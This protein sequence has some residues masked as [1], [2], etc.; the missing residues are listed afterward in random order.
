MATP[1]YN[2]KR[3]LWIIQAQKNG[4]KKVFYSSKKGQKG[5]REVLQKYDDWLEGGDSG[6]ITVSKCVELY[7]EDIEARLGRRDTYRATELYTRLYVLP[8]LGKCKMNNLSLRDWQSILNN[9]KRVKEDKPLSYKTLTHIRGIITGLHKF[10]YNN[11]YC[12]A[13]RGS[14]YIPQGHKKGERQI[15]QPQDI[16]RLFEPSDLWYINAFRVMLLC[17]LRPGECLGLQENDIGDGVLEIKRSINDDGDI[18]EGKNKNAR[19]VVPLPPL[20]ESLLRE[21]IDRNHKARFKTAWIFPNG[22]GGQ[23][24]QDCV[25]K[26]WNKLKDER[27]L[28]GT[29]YSLR[30]TFVSIVS[31]QTHLAEG[32]IKE[33]VGH[34]KSMDTF[35]TYKHTL[36][37]ELEGAAEI[38]NL[39]FERLK[40]E[41]E[42]V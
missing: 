8:A 41:G 30:H 3:E 19:R 28:P 14:L 4:I 11:Y 6:S 37:G 20:A 29:P 31:S 25:R 18:T 40:A 38:I 9:A 42:N 23:S 39:T 17:G 1:I 12:E 21:T 10:A 36:K 26:Q 24:N 32:T 5:F 7:L 35:G 2:K 27:G 33:L 34:S 16:T 15:L 22:V 13:W